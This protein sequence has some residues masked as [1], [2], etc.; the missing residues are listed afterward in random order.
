MSQ[1]NISG[2]ILDGYTNVIQSPQNLVVNKGDSIVVVCELFDGY[3]DLY[4]PT[5]DDT[6]ILKITE[7]AVSLP[8]D[9][10]QIE[11]DNGSVSVS[12]SI[13]SEQTAELV[14]QYSYKIVMNDDATV[15]VSS[16]FLY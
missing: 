7:T 4:S 6:F 10:L 8:M 13:T 15:V 1:Y 12:F 16:Q 5:I 9:F 11:G 2:V 3:G 14:N